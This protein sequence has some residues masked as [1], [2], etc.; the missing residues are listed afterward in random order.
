MIPT[1]YDS[2]EIIAYYD[3]D[4]GLFGGKV[5]YHVEDNF[6]SDEDELDENSGYAGLSYEDTSDINSDV[7][8][9]L[10]ILGL[11]DTGYVD[12]DFY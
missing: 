7:V 5:V 9:L 3:W 11:I 12:D 1:Y 10:E 4:N 6:S 2:V 8:D